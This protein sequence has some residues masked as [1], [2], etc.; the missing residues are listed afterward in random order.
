[1]RSN[2]YDLYCG[3]LVNEDSISNIVDVFQTPIEEAFKRKSLTLDGRDKTSSQILD[4]DIFEEDKK[5][6]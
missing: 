5:K 2:I 1:M 3:E 6:P 4:F